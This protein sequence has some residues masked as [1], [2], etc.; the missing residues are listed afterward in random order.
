MKRPYER[1]SVFDQIREGLKD[2]LAHARGDLTLRTTTLVA[3]A[4]RLTKSMVTAI[5]K[6]S[7]MSQAVFASFLN[8]PKRTLQ[9]WEHGAR[10][11][12]AG[13]ARLLQVFAVAP[14]EL[15]SLVSRAAGARG[16]RARP[17]RRR[18]AA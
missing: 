3:P 15:E 6:R 5:R 13:E 9:S 4:P 12:K 10:T 2:G 11:P 1:L 8:V 7:G 16:P 17:A 18:S 14:R